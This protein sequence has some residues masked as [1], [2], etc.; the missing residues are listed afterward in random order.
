MILRGRGDDSCAVTTTA[1][2]SCSGSGS[3]RIVGRRGRD[4]LPASARTVARTGSVSAAGRYARPSYSARSA[5]AARAS[6]APAPR[7]SARAFRGGGRG[8]SPRCP[9]RRRRGPRGRRREQR[10]V[11]GETGEERRERDAAVD[12]AS[13]RIRTASSRRRGGAVPGSVAR[14]IRSSSVGT[15]K[16]TCTFARRAAPRRARR[17]RAGSSGRA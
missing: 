1:S 16:L 5:A 2:A 6:R 12:P 10:G 11:V 17:R 7:G 13:V 4:A 9:S 8:R 15:E 3:G 14:Q